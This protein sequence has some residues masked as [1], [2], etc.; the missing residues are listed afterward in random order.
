MTERGGTS[1]TVSLFGF[2]MS[3]MDTIC[4]L[5]SVDHMLYD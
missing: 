2:I 4:L 3:V 5:D 1:C